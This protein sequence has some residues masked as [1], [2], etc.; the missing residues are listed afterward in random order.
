M[1]QIDLS[2][3]SSM[4]LVSVISAAVIVDFNLP[5]VVGLLAAIGF[6]GLIG[7]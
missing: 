6:G 2:M 1:G 4:Y 7:I 5:M 3:G